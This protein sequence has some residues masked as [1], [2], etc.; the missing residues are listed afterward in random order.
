MSAALLRTAVALMP[1][2]LLIGGLASAAAP[3]MDSI[4]DAL[5]VSAQA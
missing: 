5:A 4:G 3:A 2:V 1:A